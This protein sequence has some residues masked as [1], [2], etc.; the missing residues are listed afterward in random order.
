MILTVSF[1]FCFVK[2]T[3]SKSEPSCVAKLSL[4]HLISKDANLVF[5]L[6]V[7]PLFRSSTSDYEENISI[8]VCI[9]RHNGRHLKV[10]NK[11]TCSERD[12]VYQATGNNVVN[13]RGN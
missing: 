13:M 7:Y 1:A 11:G 5:Y 6:L 2:T 3:C 8:F 9:Q 4:V 12:D 10:T